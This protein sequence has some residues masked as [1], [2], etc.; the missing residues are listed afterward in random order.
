MPVS[1]GFQRKEYVINNAVSFIY[2]H[3][4]AFKCWVCA[5]VS[6]L[7]RL[8][9]RKYASEFFDLLS[10]ANAV[11]IRLLEFSFVA[12]VGVGPYI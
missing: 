11:A 10:D 12:P 1:I 4:S 8:S 3:T 5:C 9:L 2:L 7:T 6:I